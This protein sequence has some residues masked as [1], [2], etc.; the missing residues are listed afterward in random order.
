MIINVSLLASFKMIAGAHT[1]R[2]DLPDGATIRN[3]VDGVVRL[4]PKLQTHWLDEKGELRAY[5][6]I[7]VNGNEANTLPQKLD[8]V[9]KETDEIDFIPPVAGG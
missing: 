9:V 4:Y 7:F 2:L 6:H 8:T 5:V 3:V 1:I